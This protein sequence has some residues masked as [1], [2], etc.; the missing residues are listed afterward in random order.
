MINHTY[1][2]NAFSLYVQY[3]HTVAQ[4][5]FTLVV[6]KLRIIVLGDRSLF[7][8]DSDLSSRLV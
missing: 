3:V 6:I 2:N 1:K 7:I 4:E 5:H 8:N